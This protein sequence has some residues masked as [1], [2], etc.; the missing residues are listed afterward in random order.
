M[1]AVDFHQRH[2]ELAH[3]LHTDR[4]IVH[5]RAGAA[6]RELHPPHDH[7]VLRGEIILGQ[8]A[9]RR[10]ILGDLESRNHLAMLGA[11]AHQRRFAARA[12]RQRKRIEQDRFAGAG[13]ARKRGKP[14]TEIDI[15][16][17]DQDDIADGKARE[18]DT[19][20]VKMT[21]TDGG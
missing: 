8:D 9:S 18:H 17:I 2:A 13:F 3:D 16:A 15:Q 7:L 20:A 14:G 1:L 5:E 21:E 6:V 12:E 10:M 4:L 11:F 19:V